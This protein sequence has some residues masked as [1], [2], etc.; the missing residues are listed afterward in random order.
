MDETDPLID[1]T[2]KTINN[3]KTIAHSAKVRELSSL[4]LPQIDEVVNHIA[5]I[6]PAGNVPGVILN[7]LLRLPQRIPP[8]DVVRRDINLLF[9][10]VEQALLDKA[11]YGTFYATP[12]AILGAYQ[13]LLKLAGKDPETSF[14]EGIWQFY[15]DYALRDD[16]AR[17]TCETHGFDT[18]LTQHELHLSLVDRV[19]SWAMAAAHCLH[20]YYDLLENEWRE[21]VYIYILQS[22]TADRQD[23]NHFQ[24]MYRLW[25]AKRPY[26]RGQDVKPDE[27]YPAYRR[28]KFDE[29]MAVVMQG[30]PKP[31]IEK[32]RQQIR[33][34]EQNDLLA[35]QRQMSI[36]SY[37]DA[38][39]YGEVRKPV[40]LKSCHV[41]VIYQGRYY[42]LPICLPNSGSPVDVGSMR[43]LVATLMAYPVENPPAQLHKL[44][45]VKRS[46]MPDIRE[47]LSEALT[48]ELDGLR[49][50]PIWIN[51]DKRS[52][53]LPLAA[54]RQGE[55]GVG[56][57]PLTIFDTG[58]TFVFD[59][60]HI[61]FDG[62]WGVALAEILTNEALSWAVHLSA[63]PP[64]N[65]GR[66]RPYSPVLQVRSA[67]QKRFEA[68]SQVAM[69]ASAETNSVDMKEIWKLREVFKRRSDLLSMTV[70][71]LIVLYRAIHA[72]VYRPSAELIVMLESLQRDEDSETQ[73]AA[74]TALTAVKA[75][76]SRNPAILLPVDASKRSPRDRV[77]PMTFG[78]PI[79]NLD[80]LGLHQRSLAALNVYERA[81]RNREHAFA[82]FEKLQKEYLTMLAGFG[83][84]LSQ[85]KQVAV[86][87]ESM[88]VGTI[89]LLAHLPVQ[90]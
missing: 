22:L 88:S 39:I 11:V 19:T 70:N 35:Y 27:D 77:Y 15:V 17:H 29:F 82:Q 84:V 52:R 87:G 58:E 86:A 4:S 33:D 67:E 53:H 21:R 75:G 34:A 79:A 7:G 89:R 63:M 83:Q 14:P 54:I 74:K 8:P 12:A 72:A 69:E 57:H 59:L 6:A 60:S 51:A 42:L 3:L 68:A 24:R 9:K 2:Q 44:A 38:S 80:V 5:R 64:A 28:R 55:R 76:L 43:T 10:G 78:I 50:A 47:E 1:A 90:V 25:D 71:D 40:P 45:Y 73:A 65:P 20:Q 13:N 18:A 16:T 81:T 85:V 41:G 61:Y 56:D 30:L 32:W 23:A 36:R 49:L 46:A 48:N 26:S 31:I 62:V 37:L 66:K